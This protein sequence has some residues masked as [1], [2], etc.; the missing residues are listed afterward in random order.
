MELVIALKNSNPRV[1]YFKFFPW[2]LFARLY[3]YF[4]SFCG[5]GFLVLSSVGQKGQFEPQNLLLIAFVLSMFGGLWLSLSLLLPLRQTLLKARSIASKKFRTNFQVDATQ[6]RI[7]ELGEFAE[8]EIELNQIYEKI[9]K[10]N[11]KIA[12]EREELKALMSSMSDSMVGVDLNGVILFY[13][14]KFRGSFLD[15]DYKKGQKPLVEVLD[16][17]EILKAAQ[18]TI[19]QQK[20]CSVEASLPV[21]H[22][23]E[24]RTYAVTISPLYEQ[25]DGGPV[26]GAI[27]IFHDLTDSKRLQQMRIDFVTNASHELRTPMTSLKGYVEA[28]RNDL[29]EGE[30]ANVA[31]YLRIIDDNV[32]RLVHLTDDLLLISKLENGPKRVTHFQW[33]P[34]HEIC[35]SVKSQLVRLLEEKNAEIFFDLKADA[36]FG[37]RIKIE[38]I[39]INLASNAIKYL[40]K[41]GRV[42]VIFQKSTRATEL[43][44]KDNGP[45]IAGQHLPRLFERFYRVDQGRARSEGGTGLG[46]AIVKHLVQSHGGEVSVSS[47]P[48]V[49]TQFTCRFPQPSEV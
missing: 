38:Q 49:G 10:K 39:L 17:P 48:G 44:V 42:D 26:Y 32:Q 13:N 33:V 19:E 34:T 29:A 2:R 22:F 43:I 21:L 4:F 46:L 7:D 12:R 47:E 41:P 3:F 9:R 6:M 16:H 11:E 28:I 24:T 25:K 37:D 45:G 20:V 14:S 8:L 27:C 1:A 5:I 15:S 35:D 18:Q 30:T 36:V 31:K 23:S 40:G